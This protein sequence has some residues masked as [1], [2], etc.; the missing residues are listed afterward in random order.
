MQLDGRGGVSI[1]ELAIYSP[2]LVFALFVCRRHGFRRSSGWIFIVILCIIRILGSTLYLIASSSP[3][4]GLYQAV[5]TLDSMG[6]S[7]LL[8]ATLGLLSRLITWVRNDGGSTISPKFFRVAQL[9][10]TVGFILSI[11]GGV[12]T[13]STTDPSSLSQVAIILYLV[14][15]AFSIFFTA[16][17]WRGLSSSM[18]VPNG[19]RILANVVAAALPLLFLRVLF[20]AL[21]VFLHN[22]VFS[23]VHGLVGVY[24][25]MAV[26]EEAIVLVMYTAAGWFVDEID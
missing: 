17:A 15:F 21:A 12:S 8:F 2:L 18:S 7:P 14:A 11:V 1:A 13:K 4:P 6:I 10:L 16:A 20:S 26:V 9:F 5:F 19:E 25:G 3:S 22:S 24:V 23:I